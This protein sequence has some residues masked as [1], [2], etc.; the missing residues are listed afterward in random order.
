MQAVEVSLKRPRTDYI[1]LYW[2]HI[3]DQITVNQPAIGLFTATIYLQ[4]QHY[5]PLPNRI[6]ARL[7][8]ALKY[9]IEAW[10]YRLLSHREGSQR[11]ETRLIRSIASMMLESEFA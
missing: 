7:S 4:E 1:D 8:P 10:S 5:R 2:V 3:W 9:D 6:I 11:A